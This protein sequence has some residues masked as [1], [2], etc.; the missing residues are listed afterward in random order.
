[1][2]QYVKLM[3]DYSSSGLWDINGV[4]MDSTSLPISETL[5]SA[6]DAWCGD[7]EDSQFFLAPPDRDV[8]FDRITFN[9][10]GAMLAERIQNELPLWTVVHRPE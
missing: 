6:I 7:Y 3:A 5:R 10:A 9:Q 1:M 8:V 4:M 2:K